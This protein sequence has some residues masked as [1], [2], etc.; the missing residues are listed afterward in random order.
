MLR[1][2]TCS[3]TFPFPL[4]SSLTY[5][6]AG[7]AKRDVASNHGSQLLHVRVAVAL[8]GGHGCCRLVPA[9]SGLW[10]LGFGMNSTRLLFGEM[11][12]EES[13]GVDRSKWGI[14]EG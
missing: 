2:A 1:Y 5:E 9:R 3:S 10:Y 6:G 13:T 4:T 8:I 12:C 11:R 7:A 14:G